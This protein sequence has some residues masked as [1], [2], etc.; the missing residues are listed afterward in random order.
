MNGET[1]VI[2]EQHE[3]VEWSEYTAHFEAVEFVRA[4][5]SGMVV[6]APFEPETIVRRG[7]RGT[8]PSRPRG[9]KTVS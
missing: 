2:G 8:S 9:V 3:V 7:I 5:V 4:R 6:S 1:Q